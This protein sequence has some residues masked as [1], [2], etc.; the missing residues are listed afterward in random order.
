MTFLQ[1]FQNAVDLFAPLEDVNE[2]NLFS[3]D[4][5]S[6]LHSSANAAGND[7]PLYNYHYPLLRSSTS[8][9]TKLN[10][11]W[12]TGFVDAEGSFGISMVKKEEV[13]KTTLQF[14]VSQNKPNETVLK[15]MVEYFGAGNVHVDNSSTNTIK[16]QIQDLVSIRKK[17]FTHFEK[18]PPVTSKMMDYNDWKKAMDI[19]VDKKHLTTEGNNSLVEIINNM[20]NKRPKE[21]RWQYLKNINNFSVPDPNWLRGFLDGEGSFQFELSERATRNTFYIAANPTIEIAQSNH[22]VAVLNIIKDYLDSGYIKPKFNT[23]NLE[24][25]IKS[26]DTSRYVTN[27]EAKVQEFV[28]KYPLLTTKQLDYLDWKKLIAMKEQNVQ[29]TPDGFSSMLKIKEGMNKGRN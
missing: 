11:W 24:D 3:Q 1:D 22:D 28:D 21:E 5:N 25:T 13:F 15:S 2:I 10:P 7:N 26:R 6:N 17:V 29:K 14:K 18:Y 4:Y 19:L 16:F 12:I 27:D 23:E 9:I 20:N 8:G